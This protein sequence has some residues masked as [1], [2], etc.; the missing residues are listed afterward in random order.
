MSVKTTVRISTVTLSS[1]RPNLPTDG[2]SDALCIIS[3]DWFSCSLCDRDRAG[4]QNDHSLALS[5]FFTD[6]KSEE[7]RIGMRSLISSIDLSHHLNA[8]R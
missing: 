3:F 2:G 5:S 8:S 4:Y 1:P 7:V 6:S